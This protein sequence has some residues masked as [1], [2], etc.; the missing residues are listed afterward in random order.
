MDAWRTTPMFAVVL[1]TCPM[2]EAEKISKV[3]LEKRLVACANIVR[4]VLSLYW[5]NG[6]I[7]SSREALLILKTRRGLFRRLKEETLKVHPYEVPEIVL[8]N[9]EDGFKPY[10]DWVR[11]ETQSDIPKRSRRSK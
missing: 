7:E 6:R 11:R 4:D 3:L 1:I 10:L 5:W 8:L 2:D 9:I